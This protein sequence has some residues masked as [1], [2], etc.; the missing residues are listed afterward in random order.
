[1]L[2]QCL[3]KGLCAML[4]LFLTFFITGCI[5][6]DLPYPKIQENILKIEAAG[7]K[8]AASIDSTNLTATIYLDEETDIQA[9]QFT[10]FTYS[11]QATSDKDLLLGTWDLSV[12]ITVELTRYQSYQWM[13][14][15]EQEI[16]RYFT[17]SGQ[18]GQT[19]LDAVGRRI[20]VNVPENANL[21]ALEIT[22]IK[23]GPAGITTLSPYYR[24]GST[25]DL[26]SPKRIEV[27][28]W[29]RTEDWTIYAQ[30]TAQVV[31][32][33]AVDA[34]SMVAWVYGQGPEDGDNYFEYKQQG[35]S[36]WTEVPRSEITKDQGAFS[37]CLKHLT[38]LT[39]YTVRSRSG[40]NIGNEIT[41]TTQAT[42]ILPDGSFDQWWKNG[43]LWCPW[44]E[45][46]IQFWDTGNKGA[47]TL[48]E[49]NVSPSDYV[50]AG[51]T[52]QSALLKSEFKGIA[53]IGKLATGSVF[54]G[55][56]RKTDGTNGI[57]DFGRPWTL[58]P[59]K[60]KG[61]YQY[62]TGDINY[63]SKEMDY[64][65][66]RP[67]TCSIY[68]AVTDWTAPYEIRTNPNNRQLFDK[69]ASY[70][71]G[72]GNL[73]VSRQMTNYEEFE[74][75]LKYKSTSIQPSYILITCASSKYGDY[76][77]G[78]SSSVLYV[79]QLSLDYDY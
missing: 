10:E 76:F 30:R 62:S 18:I 45:N 47:T 66:G 3:Q 36:I 40:E 68:I 44:D 71:I 15:A 60:L 21:S 26:T 8:M 7:Q 53:G 57:L 31:S 48:G 20:I 43:K 58:R 2:H 34:W 6:N 73:E 52:G 17:I 5:E 41:V 70:V 38:P 1:M 78:S 61:Y 55:S 37:C 59:T 33:S 13:I 28:A 39:T 27:T 24:S 49:A 74:I 79:D 9:V 51:L 19:V 77:T 46:G 4:V 11:A 42:E 56:Y 54:S 50:P 35:A 32:T 75:E 72:Y 67:D 12:P 65:K 25:I 29:G 63:S 64:L 69:N 23:L 22:S 16:E 14:S